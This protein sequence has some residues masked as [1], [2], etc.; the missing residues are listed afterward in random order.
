MSAAPAVASRRVSTE[1]VLAEVAAS[2]AAERGGRFLLDLFETLRRQGRSRVGR[3]ELTR[4]LEQAGLAWEELGNEAG[5]N[6]CEVLVS[7][8]RRTADVAL[9][10]AWLARG[11]A[12]RLAGTPPEVRRRTLEDLV[13]LADHLRLLTPFDPYR[14]LGSFVERDTVV[15][16]FEALTAAVVRDSRALAAGRSSRLRAV[17][18]QR[19]ESLVRVLP[20]TLRGP[21]E[22]RIRA[23]GGD[24]AVPLLLDAALGKLP[25]TQDTP[26]PAVVE[27]SSPAIT[28]EESVEGR[29]DRSHGR[30]WAGV[31]AAATGISLIRGVGRLVLRGLLGLRQAATIR[32]A[33]EGLVIVERTW[34]L[35]QVVRD[36]TYAVGAGGL[37][38]LSVDRR[39]SLFVLLSGLLGGML[40]ASVGLFVFLD[41]IRG[42]YAAVMGLGLVLVA[43]GVALDMGA[44]WTAERLGSK[45]SVTLGTTDG[46]RLRVVGV[47]PA[48]ALRFVAAARGL[49]ER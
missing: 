4:R 10:E 40:G 34:L 16:A 15:L 13:P 18:T 12:A 9:V 20:A 24:P 28:A 33:P 7:G 2:P 27:P 45:A 31:L 14:M 22:D 6:V 43:T 3:P 46:K 11:L 44:L 23:A 30:T 19:L 5:G 38:L 17:I 35:G 49:L 29:C 41:G 42:E 32:T 25:A 39:V 26:A 36:H 48:R 8:P 37:T 21:L 1:D 47:E